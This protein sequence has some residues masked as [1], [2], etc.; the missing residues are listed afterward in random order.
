MVTGWDVSVAE[1]SESGDLPE[2]SPGSGSLVGV[3]GVVV[4][5][6]ARDAER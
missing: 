4:P 2:T 1:A 5:I 3:V 6:D